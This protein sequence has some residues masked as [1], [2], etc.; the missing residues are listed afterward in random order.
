MTQR[1]AA[2]YELDQLAPALPPSP[3]LGERAFRYFYTLPAAR[4]AQVRAQYSAD[5]SGFGLWLT[6]QYRRM[7]EGAENGL[8]GV[9]PDA[10]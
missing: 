9:A 3:T 2:T 1:V 7:V 6:K 4:Q 8:T 10:N 5:D